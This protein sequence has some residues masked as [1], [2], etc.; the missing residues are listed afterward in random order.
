MNRTANPSKQAAAL[1]EI[2]SF[3]VNRDRNPIKGSSDL[4]IKAL[5]NSDVILKPNH[6]SRRSRKGSKKRKSRSNLRLVPIQ[7]YGDFLLQQTQQAVLGERK[8]RERILGKTQVWSSEM[9]VKKI[10]KKRVQRKGEWRVWD[11]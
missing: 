5:G 2:N 1:S 8:L 11:S 4:R 9:A 7:K 10:N 6:F 3:Q